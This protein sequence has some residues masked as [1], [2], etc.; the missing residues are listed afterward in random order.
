L[1]KAVSAI[2]EGEAAKL[3]ALGAVAAP[4][5]Q[6]AEDVIHGKIDRVQTTDG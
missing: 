3:V 4:V 1:G 5:L 6:V 2:W